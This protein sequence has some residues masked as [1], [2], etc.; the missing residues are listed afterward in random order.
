MMWSS[1]IQ[2]LKGNIDK[3]WLASAFILVS[4]LSYEA[5]SIRQ[6]LAE[7]TPVVIKVPDTVPAPSFPERQSVPTPSVKEGVTDPSQGIQDCVFVGS[8]NSNKYHVPTSRCAKQIK[9]ENR[10][11]FTSVDTALAKGYV[12]GCLE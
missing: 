11:C 8:K 7:L 12:A 5:G 9:A 3:I 6:A 4:V 1:L 2:K 10:I